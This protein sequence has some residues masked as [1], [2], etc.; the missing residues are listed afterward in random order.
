MASA[1]R[2]PQSRRAARREVI[3]DRL[4]DV[5]QRLLDEGESRGSGAL[6]TA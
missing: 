6:S 2:K 4:L 5:V 1:T 3:R